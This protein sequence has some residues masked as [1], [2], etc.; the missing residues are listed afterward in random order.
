V[1]ERFS[2]AN[3]ENSG[4]YMLFGVRLEVNET[5]ELLN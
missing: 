1:K 2:E 5:K 3:M 4:Y